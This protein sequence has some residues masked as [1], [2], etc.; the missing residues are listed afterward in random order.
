MG[1]ILESSIYIVFGLLLVYKLI[2]DYIE[3]RLDNDLF[4]I[5]RYSS[6]H[7]MDCIDRGNIICSVNDKQGI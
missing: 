4:N 5:G 6:Q 1:K 7:N 3:E 2:N